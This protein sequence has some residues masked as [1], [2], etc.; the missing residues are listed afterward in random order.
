MSED[1]D[2]AENVKIVDNSKTLEPGGEEEKKLE[3]E[4][5][6]FGMK[7]LASPLK[8]PVGKAI[9]EALTKSKGKLITDLKPEDIGKINNLRGRV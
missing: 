7:L 3:K 9:I 5:A 4:L 2:K 1:C 8:N 6:K